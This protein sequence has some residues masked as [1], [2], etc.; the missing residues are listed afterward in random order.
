MLSLNFTNLIDSD[1][2]ILAEQ[3]FNLQNE[4]SKVMWKSW[5]L[6]NTEKKT[7]LKLQ[8]EKQRCM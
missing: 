5:Y 8:E 1:M 2:T 3:L 7:F 6:V 4:T